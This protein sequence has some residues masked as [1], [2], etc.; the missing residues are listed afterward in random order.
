M[1][2]TADEILD[3]I[4][5]VILDDFEGDLS[6]WTLSSDIAAN[7]ATIE[8][9][10][11]DPDNKVLQLVA[12]EGTHKLLLPWVVDPNGVSTL[13]F[14]MAFLG[15]TGDPNTINNNVTI[16]AADKDAP[17]GLWGEYFSLLRMGGGTRIDYRD[18][19][20]Y[21]TAAETSE[22]LTWYSFKMYMDSAS[23]SY[24]LYIDGVLIAEGA[25]FRSDDPD[26]I[27]YVFILW[28]DDATSVMYIDDIA[29]QIR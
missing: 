10:P 7:Y 29:G 27:A 22:E 8:E 5:P 15:L 17:D 21:V 1:A 14:R 28:K 9:D 11:T 26:G 20:A 6:A 18:G 4:G 16:G 2:L 24:D 12:A 3:A 25:G 13:S 23:M 19:G